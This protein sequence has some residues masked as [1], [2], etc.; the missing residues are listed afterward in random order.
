MKTIGEMSQGESFEE[1]MTNVKLTEKAFSFLL[2]DSKEAELKIT[3]S[4][5]LIQINNQLGLVNV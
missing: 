3:S 2:G 4:F 1:I 5:S